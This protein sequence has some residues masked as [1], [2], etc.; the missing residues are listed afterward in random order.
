MAESSQHQAL[1]KRTVEFIE[2]RYSAIY[3]LIVIHDIVQHIG[4]KKPPRIEGYSPDVFAYD[5]P[6]TTTIIGEAKTPGDLE[7]LHSRDQLRAFAEYLVTRPNGI[8]IVSV[9]FSIVPSARRVLKNILRR[10]DKDSSDIEI[11]IVDEF[12]HHALR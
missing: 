2:S 7:T 12:G 9:T 8:L 5:V 11:L 4:E 10:L 3:S 6:L 1:L